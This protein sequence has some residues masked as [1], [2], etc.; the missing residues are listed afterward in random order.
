MKSKTASAEE[1]DRGEKKQ[2]GLK[3]R[4]P[5]EFLPM[6]A[7]AAEE[8]AG[9]EHEEG[10]GRNRARDRRF[11]E[12]VL[13]GLQRGNRN[14]QLRQVPKCGVEQTS[15]RISGLG[16]DGLCGMTEQGG[17]RDDGQ[18]R[19]NEVQRVGVRLELLKH[20]HD[21]HEDEQPEERI[22]PDFLKEQ[23]HGDCLSKFHKAWRAGIGPQSDGR[24]LGA[25]SDMDE[26]AKA[27]GG[28]G[29]LRVPK[30]PNETKHVHPYG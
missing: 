4:H 1:R 21:R 15:D 11:H 10:V 19:E 24:N 27:S 3:S 29:N 12:R 17:E 23:A 28:S 14:H 16:G 25:C 9:A 26:A 6:V 18:D 13:P 2:A 30:R 5:V 8:K 7:Q 22:M 20:E